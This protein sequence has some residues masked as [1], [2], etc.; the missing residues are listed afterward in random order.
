MLL[1]FSNS[2]MLIGINLAHNVSRI[3]VLIGVS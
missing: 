1:F 2:L 3:H